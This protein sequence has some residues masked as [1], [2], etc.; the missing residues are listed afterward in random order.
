MDYHFRCLDDRQVNAFSTPNG[1][2][3]ITRGLLEIIES[4]DELAIV[5]A[6]EMGHIERKHAVVR[7]KQALA[8]ALIG[9][10]FSAQSDSS[11]EAVMVAVAVELVLKGFSREQEKE[12]D[13]VAVSHLKHSGMDWFA[14]RTLF[15]R[16]IDFRERRVLGIEAVFSTHPQPESRTE[17]LDRMTAAYQGFLGKLE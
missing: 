4:D 1:Y 11:T 17:E 10:L 6:H 7:Y 16:F 8:L 12:A 13:E 5:I 3:Y 2:I 14:Y 15:G 9:S